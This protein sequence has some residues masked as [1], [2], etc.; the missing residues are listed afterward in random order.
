MAELE[1]EEV[2]GNAAANA[3]EIKRVKWEASNEFNKAIRKLRALNSSRVVNT[4]SAL[5]LG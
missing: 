5:P 3:E 1:K 4:C 2:G